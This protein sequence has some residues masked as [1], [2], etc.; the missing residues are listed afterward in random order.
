[1]WITP[2][3]PFLVP[4]FLGLVIAFTY[5]DVLFTLLRMIGIG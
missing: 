2:G 3:I 1:V 4:V 5:G